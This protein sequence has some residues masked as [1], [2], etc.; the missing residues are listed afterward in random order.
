MLIQFDEAY[1]NSELLP[2]CLMFEKQNIC[3]NDFKREII[4]ILNCVV[5]YVIWN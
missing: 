3:L 2:T 4:D 1:S 5:K